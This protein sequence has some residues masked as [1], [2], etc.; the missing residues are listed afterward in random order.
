MKK[1]IAG[2]F[3]AV[4]AILVVPMTVQ[5]Y[6]LDF[7]VVEDN[8]GIAAAIADQ[9]SVEVEDGTTEVSFTFFNDVD[10]GSPASITDV[11][12]DD[13]LGLFDD[14]IDINESAG[15]LFSE[16]AAPGN[17]PGG[18]SI[19]FTADFSA[20]SDA[21]PISNG[22]DATGEWVKIIFDYADFI[23]FGDVVTALGSGDLRV[24]M[25]VQGTG[26][27]AQFSDTFVNV[28]EPTTMLLFGSGLVGLMLYG[29]KRFR[30]ETDKT[31]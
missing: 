30:K 20:D 18:N 4:F 22:V 7:G 15:V 6:T 23:D 27:N 28:P 8:S 24:G 19:G 3:L 17:L 26:E 31:S 5:A 1:I 10:S 13:T 9:L 29:R 12:F 16:F 21:P 2:M 11:Y 25:H 14:L